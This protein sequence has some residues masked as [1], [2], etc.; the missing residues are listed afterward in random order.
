VRPAY[1][2]TGV[3]RATE[4]VLRVV[5]SLADIPATEWNALASGHPFL[6]HEIFAALHETRCACEETGWLPQFLVVTREG[7]VE[8][9]MPL[10][11]KSHS[12]GEYVF[13]WAWADAYERHGLIYYPKLLSAVPFSP[14]TGSRLLARDDSTRALLIG[15]ALELAR[16]TSS[17]HVLYPPE[18]EAREMEAAGMMLRRG[19]Q[20]HWQNPG[21]RDFEEFLA[22]LS[23]A[24]RKKIRQ[25]RRKARAA[26]MRFRHIVGTDIGH[27]EWVFFTRCYNRTYRAHY[28]TPYLNLAFFKQL[29]ATL[30][31]NVLLVVAEREGMPFAAA[32]NVFTEDVLYGRYWGALGF[33]P[34][35]HF[36]V[37]Y[38][39]TMEFCIDRGI[40]LFEGGAQGEHKLSRGF[41]PVETWSA[42]WLRHPRFADAI[43]EFL[44][45]E[46]RGIEH[47]IDELNDRSPFKHQN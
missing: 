31:E 3:K 37:C 29:G 36:E 23:H 43:G 38:Y 14:V 27:D 11:L 24:K 40:R 13:D 2:R 30:P 4:P 12:Y 19:V 6:R 5:D 21:Y 15:T 35:L 26:D 28:S 17:L 47:Y 41:L 8:G 32:L 18:A 9:I 25:E 46:A 34:A 7:R 10:Y 1:R 33:L 39:Q 22:T 42:H 20:F 45:R 16:Q 44:A